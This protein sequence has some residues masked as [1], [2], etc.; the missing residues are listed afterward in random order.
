MT[1]GIVKVVAAPT[2]SGKTGVLELAILNTLSKRL[3][4]DDSNFS[5]SVR[6][7]VIYLAPSKALVQVKSN[8][9]M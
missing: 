4:L 8:V 9:L 6:L 7:R 3:Q 2:G 5:A 1:Q